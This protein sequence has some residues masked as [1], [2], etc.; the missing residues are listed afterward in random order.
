M[1]PIKEKRSIFTPRG[2]WKKKK[3]N[4]NFKEVNK[5]DESTNETK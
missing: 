4:S 2:N 3:L 1:L 5:K